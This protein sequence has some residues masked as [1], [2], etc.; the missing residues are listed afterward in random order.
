MKNIYCKHKA[1]DQ[2]K[3]PIIQLTS[4]ISNIH[5]IMYVVT[6]KQYEILPLEQHISLTCLMHQVLSSLVFMCINTNSYVHRYI[7]NKVNKLIMIT[8][9]FQLKLKFVSTHSCMY[10]L[11]YKYVELLKYVRVEV[12]SVVSFY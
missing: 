9:Y 3:Y 10:I 11:T 8:T 5:S 12:E 1:L 6:H 2:R 7:V 4:C